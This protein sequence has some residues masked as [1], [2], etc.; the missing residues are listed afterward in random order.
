MNGTVGDDGS[1]DPSVSTDGRHVAFVSFAY[2]DPLVAN[3][4]EIFV[5]DLQLNTTTLVSRANGATGAVGDFGSLSPSISAD[6]RRV[7]FTSDSGNLDSASN[8]S[9]L[10]VFVRNL[11]ANTITFVSRATGAGGMGGDADSQEPSISADGTKV[12][13]QSAA[14]QLDSA[15][16][17][18]YTDSFVRN[19]QTNTTIL[20]SRA[21]GA[22]G[23]AGNQ[24]SKVPDISPDGTRVA[25]S[26]AASNFD[27]ASNDVVYDI[28]VRDPI[29]GPP[30]QLQRPSAAARPRPRSGR[31][32]TT[33]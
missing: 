26:S 17:D 33:R 20:V 19:L 21:S 31:A 15:S 24:A 30:I 4:Q 29:P 18:S 23:A 27:S 13:F 12:A 7:A 8:D 2:L 16:N 3:S 9:Y 11:D 5:R 25:F 32:G 28:F 14:R 1:F 6:G 10:D 22:G